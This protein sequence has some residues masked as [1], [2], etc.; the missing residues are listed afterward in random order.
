MVNILYQLA[1]VYVNASH[2]VIGTLLTIINLSDNTLLPYCSDAT[3]T[4]SHI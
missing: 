2:L 3:I 1:F 4:H